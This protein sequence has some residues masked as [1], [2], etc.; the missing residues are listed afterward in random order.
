MAVPAGH[1]INVEHEDYKRLV[2]LGE[3]EGLSQKQFSAA[4][5][6]EFERHAR[7]RPA[8]PAPAPTPKPVNFETMTTR[9]A[10]AFALANSPAAKP[11][12]G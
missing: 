5:G 11:R 3:R 8:A 7:A 9:E 1:S 6:Y 4:L 12:G 2:A 10:F